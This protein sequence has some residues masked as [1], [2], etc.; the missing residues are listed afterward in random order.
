MPAFESVVIIRELSGRKRTVEL[1]GPALPFQ[2]ANWG[3]E[4]RV[5]TTWYAGNATEAT[6]QVLGP[7]EKQTSW[8][9]MWRTTQMVKTPSTVNE[10]G[11]EVAILQANVIRDVLESI[12]RRGSALRVTW[13]NKDRS[14]Q[15]EGRCIEWDFA[16][17]RSDDIAWDMTWDW[18]GRGVRQQRAVSTRKNPVNQDLQSMALTALDVTVIK[19]NEGLASSRRDVRLSADRFTLG[20]LENL[21]NAPLETTRSFARKAQQ[22]AD[23]AQQLGEIINTVRSLPFQVANQALDQANNAVSIANNFVDEISRRPPE[24]NST[25]TKVSNL[26]RTASFF[27]QA[28]NR[29]RLMS[30]SATRVRRRVESSA[31]SESTILATHITRRGETL[32]SI[33]RRYYGTTD[34]APTIARANNLPLN[35]TSLPER[36]LLIIPTIEQGKNFTPQDG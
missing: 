14:I 24:Q 20:Q 23:R 4:Q 7:I 13:S 35:Q 33:S 34:E 32:Q 17:D 28:D 5:R 1:R 12:F 30:R 29:A 10:N 3:G 27:G 19:Q 8:D 26:T 15:R 2:G 6:Q 36:T 21:V 11:R 25:K 18:S 9:G 31:K 22:I 16:Y